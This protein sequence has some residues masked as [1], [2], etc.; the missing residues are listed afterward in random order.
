[1]PSLHAAALCFSV[2]E[3]WWKLFLVRFP[4]YGNTH[5]LRVNKKVSLSDIMNQAWYRWFYHIYWVLLV[6]NVAWSSVYTLEQV[7]RVDVFS[8][9]F[10]PI[11]RFP[12]DQFLSGTFCLVLGTFRWHG[13]WLEVI[14]S[15]WPHRFLLGLRVYFSVDVVH[16][17]DL[18]RSLIPWNC[19]LV[20]CLAHAV[21][22]LRHS[23]V[24]PWE[25]LLAAIF[26]VPERR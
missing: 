14:L 9:C 22:I 8:R 16:V 26:S 6:Q 23:I 12:S 1:M 10:S 4:G 7:M 21:K 11:C 15:R 13:G 24:S 3:R 17:M 18:K 25:R 20:L 2:E 5:S 19:E